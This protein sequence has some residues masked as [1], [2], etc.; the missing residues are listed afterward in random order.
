[1]SHDACSQV[2]I[3]ACTLATRLVRRSV[4][5]EAIKENSAGRRVTLTDISSCYDT[6]ATEVGGL[7]G[8][9]VDRGCND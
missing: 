9:K 4:A 1:M 5:P 8:P 3:V 6:Q 7:K 2:A